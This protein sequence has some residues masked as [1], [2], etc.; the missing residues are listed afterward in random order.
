MTKSPIVIA[1]AR[2]AEPPTSIIAM[3]IAPMTSDENAV[4]AETP[5]SDWATLRNS[6]CAPFAK[7]SSSRFSAVYALT[8]RTPPSDSASRPVTSALICPR[9][10][11]S[12]RRRLNAVAIPPPNSD[13]DDQRDHRQLPVQ[14]EEDA[15]RDDRGEDRAGQL[16]QAGA[17]QI[18][19]AFGV[20]HDPRDQDAGLGRV[21]VADRQPHDVRLDVLAHLGDRALRGDAEHLRVGERRDRVDQSRRGAD[22]QGERGQQ[23]PVSLGDDVVHQVF[24]RRRQHEAGEPVDQ[25]QRQPEGEALAMG[26]DEAARFFPRAGGERFLLGGFGRLGDYRRRG[27]RSA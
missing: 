13:E 4:T 14:V 1:P 27:V 24:R 25:H 15:E 7:T 10:R 8:M 16:H 9:S 11:N 21:E 5:V 17:D 6:R 18:P 12:G 2:I 19:D 23:V 20:G 22:R 26:P 3:P